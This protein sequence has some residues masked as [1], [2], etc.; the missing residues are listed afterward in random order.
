MQIEEKTALAY[1][2]V[3][4]PACVWHNL[5]STV[6][7]EHALRRG[8]AS[9]LNTGALVAETGEHTG[10]SPK[11]KF[12]VEEP[13]SAANIWWHSGNQ[14]ISSAHFDHL[15]ARMR[16]F[17]AEREVYAQDLFASA[18]PNYRLRVRVVTELAWHNLFAQHL[19][20]RP[21]TEE[22]ASFQP[23]WT[24]ISIPSV[25]A[26]P[27]VDG[28]RSDTFVLIN[29]ARR[30]V[31]IGGTLYA[32]E[33]KKA[34][35]T[36]LNYLLPEQGVLSMH[37]SANRGEDGST[38]IFFGLSGTGKTTLSAD[39]ERQLIGD[40]EHGW[41]EAG[42]FNFEG[43]CYAKT[44]GLSQSGEPEIWAATNRSGTVLENVAFDPDSRQPDYND[45]RLT[46]NTRSAYPIEAIP[47]VHL[48]GVGQHPDHVVFLSYDIFGIL[49][50]VACLDAEQ[51][52]FFFLSGY[53]SKVA[54]TERG[55][56][57][58][59]PVFSTCFA[60]PF[61]PLHPNTYA[62]L[63]EK[64]IARHGSKVWL[65]NTGL[66]GGP[67][68]VGER[69]SLQHTR[70]IIRAITSGQLDEAATRIDPVFGLRVP[71]NVPGVPESIL[72]PRD[73]WSDTAYYDAQA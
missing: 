34:V 3:G 46:E 45:G 9:L 56:K 50:P 42:I 4:S 12:F 69:I 11:D 28:T 54:G 70:A 36:I 58:P 26:D 16:A 17:M 57:S 22:Q 71:T 53:T 35:F 8:E 65:L 2:G 59:E 40:D 31:L 66:V 23:D 39:S 55:L 67:Y 72:R 21:T 73:A 25:T 44:I 33:I 7:F 5:G 24:V 6:L 37:C 18:D 47:G 13:S 51:T 27:A 49:P 52:R 62:D 41:S 15:F 1:L 14:P 29:L 68:G 60:S 20:R 61:L 64:R 38:A 48:A 10:R 19:L 30:M 43:G 32:G 63:L